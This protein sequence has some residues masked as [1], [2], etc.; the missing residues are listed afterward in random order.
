MTLIQIKPPNPACGVCSTY[1][2][3]DQNQ[4]YFV[5]PKCGAIYGIQET[6]E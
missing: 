1:M 2:V 3:A 5:C 6:K 4:V